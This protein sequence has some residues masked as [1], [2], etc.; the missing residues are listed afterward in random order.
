MSK[1]FR[2]FYRYLL[3]VLRKEWR[4]I[5]VFFIFL[6]L[7]FI[8]VTSFTPLL[9]G[10]SKQTAKALIKPVFYEAIVGNPGTFNPL[11]SKMESEKEIN[12][13]VFSGLVKTSSDGKIIGDLA[14]SWE[15]KSDTKYI[16]HLK[17]NI[18]WQ[19]GVKFT[20]DDV[21]YTVETAQNPLYQSDLA[22]DLKDIQISKIDSYTVG[23]QLKESF[24]P[25]LSSLT[26]G[27]IPKH[28]PL[29]NYR[30]V[31]T[32]SFKFID[33]NA[34]NSTLENQKLKLKFK[35]YPSIET[36]LTAFKLG[37]VHGI[38]GEMSEI[39]TL[40]DWKNFQITSTVLP[41]RLVAAFFNLREPALGEKGVRQALSFATPK[42]SIINYTFGV[43][44][45]IALNSLPEVPGSQSK[46]TER[47]PYNLE[48]AATLLNNAGWVLKDNIRTKNGKKLSLAITTLAD[49]EYE[50]T[51]IKMKNSWEKLGVLVSINAVS[52]MELKDSIVPSRTFDV[53]LSSQ[54]LG[55]DPD[56]YVLWHTTQVKE[57]NVSGITSPKIDKLLED[58]RKSLDPKV[59]TDKYQEFTRLLSDEA[60]AIFLYYPNYNWDY[61]KRVSGVDLTG[62]TEPET[63]FDSVKSWQIK[64]PLL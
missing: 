27:I 41:Y 61:S 46:A 57:S 56:Q 13:L 35:Y 14:E 20:A 30:P 7:G 10:S 54:L 55:T 5:S 39:Y 38:S 4:L 59:R 49:K 6:I 8:F 3:A 12:S 36:A 18:L 34:D 21:T 51:A 32:G 9:L 15:I 1:R 11:F 24:A 48:K 45:K 26:F 47:Y 53:L 52:G 50:D 43:K 60:P 29:N 37:E 28:I 58:G 16:I 17:K 25:F 23:F 42:D 33:I 63:R 19:D 62:F 64:V 22:N 40:K 44:G 2:F 31:G